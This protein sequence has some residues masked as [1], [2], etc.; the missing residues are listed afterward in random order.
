MER[1]LCVVLCTFNPSTI[2]NKM[3]TIDIKSCE[4]LSRPATS[5]ESQPFYTNNLKESGEGVWEDLEGK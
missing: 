2:G 4:L 1:K 5:E 3:N